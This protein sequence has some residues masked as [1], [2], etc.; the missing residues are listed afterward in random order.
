MSIELVSSRL[1]L[2]AIVRHEIRKSI[3]DENN[4]VRDIERA[5]NKKE[6]NNNMDSLNSILLKIQKI[7]PYKKLNED[8]ENSNE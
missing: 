8:K 5:K 1:E 3:D 7:E 4:R 2:K 6:F